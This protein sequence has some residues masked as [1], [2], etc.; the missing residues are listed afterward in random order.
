M[1]AKK[2][3]LFHVKAE[4]QQWTLLAKVTIRGNEI[5]IVNGYF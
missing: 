2:I 5:M 4:R 3:S 1:N